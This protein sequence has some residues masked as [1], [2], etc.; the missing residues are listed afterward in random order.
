MNH[1]WLFWSIIAAIIG[2]GG[3]VADGTTT[4]F[5]VKKDGPGVEGDLSKLAQWEVRHPFLLPW[6]NGICVALCLALLI[7]CGPHTED[8]GYFMC[9]VCSI[10]SA[11][12]GYIAAY[13][14]YKSNKSIK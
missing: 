10:A 3:Q 11:I 9:I 2:V 4:Y 5:G 6:F 1:T 14:N 13:N 12:M 8:G 7:Y